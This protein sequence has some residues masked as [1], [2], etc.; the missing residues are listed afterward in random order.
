MLSRLL[1]SFL[2]LLA[3]FAGSSTLSAQSDAE[4]RNHVN[5]GAVSIVTSGIE[6]VSNTYLTLAGE[7]AETLDKRKDLRV[8]PMMGYGAVQNVQDVLYLRGVDIAM[9][10]SDVIAHLRLTKSSA[11]AERRLAMLLKLYDEPFHVLARKEITEVRQLAGKPVVVA[12]ARSGSEMSA[13]TMLTMQGIEPA[14]VHADWN[15][16]V[17]MLRTGKAA[18]MIYPTRVVS[19]FLRKLQQVEALHFLP[20]SPFAGMEGAYESTMLRHEDYPNLIPQGKSVQTLQMAT[21]LICYNWTPGTDRY[22]KVRKFMTALLQDLPV[23]QSPRHHEVWRKLDLAS[24]A[25]GWRRWAPAEELIAAHKVRA[26][27][28][29]AQPGDDNVQQLFREFLAWRERTGR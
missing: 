29:Q 8:L 19:E 26:R 4:I 11:N 5:R 3:I 21:I 15:D 28:V 6:Y 10:H 16:G 17:E 20:L 18:A 23:L 14:Y 9:V 7:M 13:R 12:V 1:L 24:L 25:P 22:G 2:T 27:G